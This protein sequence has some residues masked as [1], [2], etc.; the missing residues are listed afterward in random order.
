[1]YAVDSKGYF[2]NN[3]L[4]YAVSSDNNL[5]FVLNS[6]LSWW[7]LNSLTTD[8]QNSYK[9]LYKK[10]VVQMPV[11]G[12]NPVYSSLFSKLVESS[13]HAISMEIEQKINLLVYHLYNLTAE[14]CRII[15]PRFPYDQAQYEAEVQRLLEQYDVEA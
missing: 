5:V 11:F 15:D 6:S 12:V 8:L 13:G 4:H 9:Q 3:A 1:M 14:E 7:F 10:D 2:V